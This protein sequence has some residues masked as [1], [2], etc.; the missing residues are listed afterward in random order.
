MKRQHVI[1]IILPPLIVVI[2]WLIY[3]CGQT[4]EFYNPKW[5][6]V[7]VACF[8]VLFVSVFYIPRLAQSCFVQ[9]FRVSPEEKLIV[10]SSYIG[11][12]LAWIIVCLGF[13][14]VFVVWPNEL[15]R[16]PT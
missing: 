8:V 11:F 16:L 4:L 13:I 14:L 6:Y 7:T 9:S 2:L 10:R 5:D 15:L 12:I 3:I 1:R